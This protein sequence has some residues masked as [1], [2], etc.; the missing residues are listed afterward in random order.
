MRR[1]RYIIIAAIIAADQ[2]VKA[3]IRGNMQVGDSFS[4]I[5]NFFSITYVSNT[6]GAMSTFEGNTLLLVCLPIAA[7]IFAVFY[8]EKHLSAHITLP[9]SLTLIVSGGI[10]N[11]ID[12]I[13]F[14]YVTDFLDF[15]SIPLWNW[16]FNIADIAICV[17]CF[18]LVL[19][20]LFFDKPANESEKKTAKESVGTSEKESAKESE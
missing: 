10:G 14:G 2:I 5:D 16:V 9:A 3:V 1:F 4:V 7:I 15:T 12:R 17:G 6:G 19:Y 11:L 13:V 8:M 18:L 20:V